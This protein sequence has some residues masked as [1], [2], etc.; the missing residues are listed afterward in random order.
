MFMPPTV[1]SLHLIF[2]FLYCCQVLPACLL[3]LVAF[4]AATAMCSSPLAMLN[5]LAWASLSS[6]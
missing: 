1:S 3:P 5:T 4:A 6:V 2:V